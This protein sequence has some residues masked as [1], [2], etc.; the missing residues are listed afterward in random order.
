MK[1][2][3]FSTLDIEMRRLISIESKILPF[4]NMFFLFKVMVTFTIPCGRLEF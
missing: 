2:R 3:T 1:C 4:V